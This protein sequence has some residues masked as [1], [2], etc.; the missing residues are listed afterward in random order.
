MRRVVQYNYKY[1]GKVEPMSFIDE[2]Y[3]NV[4]KTADIV[5]KKAGDGIEYSKLR[6]RISG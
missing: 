1:Y 5:G 4:K 3:T 2:V 6:L